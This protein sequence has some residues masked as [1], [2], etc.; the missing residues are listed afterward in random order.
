MATRSK[1]TYFGR[2]VR[3][4]GNRGTDHGSAQAMMVCGGNINGGKVYGSF[5]GISNAD[6]YLNADLAVT[7]DFRRPLSDIVTNHLGNSEIPTVFPGYN[8]NN[9]MGLIKNRVIPSSEF[10][11]KG[12]FE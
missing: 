3:E 8:G 9:N 4:N 11:F 1:L 12:G 2:R 5:P 6:L 10:I 7:T